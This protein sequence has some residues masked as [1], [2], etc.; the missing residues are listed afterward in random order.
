MGESCVA[1]GPEAGNVAFVLT[2]AF[3]S[4]DDGETLEFDLREGATHHHFFRRGPIA[5]HLLSTSGRHARILFAFPA[6]NVGAGVWLEP[7]AEGVELAVL[8]RLTPVEREDGMRGVSAVITSRAPLL[9]VRGVVLGSVRGLRD[10]IFTGE[11]P[12]G[13][14]STIEPG[15]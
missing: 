1:S 4:S 6:G 9:C 5:A 3:R 8:G 15:P 14:V 2:D 10:F 13:F 12:A 11:A 7:Y